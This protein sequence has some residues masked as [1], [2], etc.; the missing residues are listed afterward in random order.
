M[1][2]TNQV[3]IVTGASSGIGK[4]TALQLAEAGAVVVVAARRKERLE[5]VVDKIEADGGE[6]I[7]VQTDVRDEK[8]VTAMVDTVLDSFGSI[9]ILINN[10]GVNGARSAWAATPEKFKQ[11]LEVN[12]LG[13]MNVTSATLDHML[14]SRSGHIVNVSSS[15]A[16]IPPAGGGGYNASKTGL[17]GFSE[18]LRKAV[19]RKGIHVTVVMPGRVQTEI[20]SWEEWDGTPLQPEDVADAIGYAIE[21]PARASVN[22]LVLRPTDQP[23]P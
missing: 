18:S 12:L 22:E 1:A 20:A 14:K 11:I 4:A 19:T 2:L 8:E 23:T 3:A 7:A 6:A 5:E 17:N 10:A 15:N 16:L 9:D 13:A 21:Q